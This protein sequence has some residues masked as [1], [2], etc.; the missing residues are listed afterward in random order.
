[1]ELDYLLAVNYETRQGALRFTTGE[2]G[3]F[4]AGVDA[5][6]I[7]E[8]VDL[9]R[10]LSA[11]E[12]LLDD[13][14]SDEDLRLLLASGSSLGGARPKTSV[15]DREGNLLIA[16]FP[17]R[18][19]EYQTVLWEAVALQLVSN[20]GLATPSWR[21]EEI[22]GK[23]VLLLD[24]FDRVDGHRVPFLSAMS[25]LNAKDGDEHSYL[26]IVD[27]LRQSGAQPKD[28]IIDLWKRIVLLF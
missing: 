6:P 13:Q 24:R 28:D 27:A 3:E 12:R 5:N 7:P 19:D 26:E 23:H 15:K 25:M 2:D 8:L 4:L 16:K 22:T 21:L 10:L 14:E 18:D 20:A 17:R 1:M 11:T 9:P